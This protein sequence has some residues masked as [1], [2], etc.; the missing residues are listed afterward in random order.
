MK[1]HILVRAAA[2]SFSLGLAVSE[3][4]AQVLTPNSVIQG[5]ST[6]GTPASGKAAGPLGQIRGGLFGQFAAG[7]NWAALGE[8]PFGVG[9]VLPYGL[10]LQK[11]TQFGLF[12]QVTNTSVNAE[13]LVVGWGQNPNSLLRFRFISDQFN[14]VF[15]DVLKLSGSTAAPAA[16]ITAAA[17]PNAGEGLLSLG[18][19][20]ATGSSLVY[21]C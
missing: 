19:A 3:T 1:T 2:L 11:N 8:S 5:P 16:Q 15:T 7:D 20:D 12:N 14:N 13:D 10:R 18:V 21:G 4:R 17:A 9:G 6:N